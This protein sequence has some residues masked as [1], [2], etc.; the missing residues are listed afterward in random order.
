MFSTTC[1]C[2]NLILLGGTYVLC[3]RNREHILHWKILNYRN[4]LT[5]ITD[6]ITSK[7]PNIA[8][9]IM[10]IIIDDFST[11][12]VTSNHSFS[13]SCEFSCIVVVLIAGSSSLAAYGGGPDD[14]Y[15]FDMFDENSNKNSM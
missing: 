13:L 2:V 10:S 9:T 15:I 7:L 4:F 3:L 14:P 5:R 11:N 8:A 12:I 6:T 1:A